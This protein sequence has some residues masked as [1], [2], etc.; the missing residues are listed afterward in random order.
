MS[1]YLGYADYYWEV[2]V[3]SRDP[4]EGFRILLEERRTGKRHPY[5]VVKSEKEMTCV[6][7]LLQRDLCLPEE[8]FETKYG[9]RLSASEEP[10]SVP[11][12]A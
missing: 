6:C 9:V 4:R 11:A 7:R 8:D 1:R 12:S 10:A 3:D 2:V 5:R